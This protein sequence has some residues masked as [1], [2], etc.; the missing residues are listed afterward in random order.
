MT[1]TV[2][3]MANSSAGITRF[4]FSGRR[5]QPP[6]QPTGP[7]SSPCCSVVTLPGRPP[8]RR[9]LTRLNAARPTMT[10]TMPGIWAGRISSPS[11]TKLQPTASA[12]WATCRMPIVADVDV[13]LGGGDQSVGQHPGE[14]RQQRDGRPALGRQRPDLVAGQDQRDRCGRQEADRHHR[15]HEVDDVDRG[16][17][18][19]PRQQVA[20]PRAR[21]RRGRGHR[22]RR[23][24]RPGCRRGT[25]RSPARRSTTPPTPRPA[26][27]A[28]RRRRSRQPARGT[29][30]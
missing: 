16:P 14:H 18:P 20:D 21:P 25:A 9:W 19:P 10:R 27:S 1:T 17:G 23:S 7:A 29:A 8:D 26:G 15:R 3:A 2:T 12:G 6:S 30:G 5:R 4:R 22:R 28:A 24:R 13:P 11:S